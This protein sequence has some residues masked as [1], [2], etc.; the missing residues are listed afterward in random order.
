MNADRIIVVENGEILQQGNH[1]ELIVSGGRYADLWS[2]QVFIRPND[3]DKAEG[4]TD[5]QA[6][7]VNDLSSEQTRTELS[8]VKPTPA[9]K[10]EGESSQQGG[11][12]GATATPNRTQEAS[13]LNPVAPTF[14][15][16]SLGKIRLGPGTEASA[17][18]CG[19]KRTNTV[20]TNAQ[21][22]RRWSDEVDEEG[23][24]LPLKKIEATNPSQ[25]G[26][27]QDGTRSVVTSSN[28]VERHIAF[29]AAVGRALKSSRRDHREGNGTTNDKVSDA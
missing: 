19:V 9:T 2:K 11:E 23:V 28:K 12:E 29:A 17:D 21:T 3:D 6:G 7:F 4:A 25:T 26:D 8:K 27:K 16:R 1:N 10:D 22:S 13:R 14:T 18:E 20:M 15:P 5:G 24:V